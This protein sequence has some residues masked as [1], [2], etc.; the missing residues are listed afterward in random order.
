MPSTA[1]TQATVK[2]M[3]SEVRVPDQM[4]AQMS[5]TDVVGA[6]DEAFLSGQEVGKR[7]PR[8]VVVDGQRVALAGQ[9]RLDEGEQK[10]QDHDDEEEHGDAVFEEHPQ[11]RPPVGVV[12]I[13]AALGLG[14]VK[15][16]KGEKLLVGKPVAAAS[17]EG[18]SSPCGGVCESCFLSCSSRAPASCSVFKSL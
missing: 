18:A 11:R 15:A 17:A 12:G 2:P 7:A 16:G 5:L 3:N 6:E 10:R 8:L 9:K 1:S 13:A 14:G 4:R